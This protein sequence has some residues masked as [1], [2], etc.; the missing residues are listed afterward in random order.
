MS[1]IVGSM[2][3]ITTVSVALAAL[4]ASAGP[5]VGGGPPAVKKY[6]TCKG[7]NDSS[8][9]LHGPSG[10]VSAHSSAGL[11]AK[12]PIRAQLSCQPLLE[13]GIV[14]CQS[15]VK[16]GSRLNV[17]VARTIDGLIEAK[18]FEV[19]YG[20]YQQIDSLFCEQN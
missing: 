13:N 6:L 15:K 2:K 18:V 16:E 10:T 12:D 14:E 19:Q 1:K 20:Q 8:L 9:V 7:E 11:Y 5:M 3:W 4:S 17:V